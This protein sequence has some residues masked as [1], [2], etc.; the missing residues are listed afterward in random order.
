MLLADHALAILEEAEN[1]AWPVTRHLQASGQVGGKFKAITPKLLACL[2]R[3]S[4][5]LGGSVA[6]EFWKELGECSPGVRE[7]VQKLKVTPLVPSMNII[8]AVFCGQEIDKI[9]FTPVFKMAQEFFTHLI[10]AFNNPGGRKSPVPG[11]V[12]DVIGLSTNEL[13]ELLEAHGDY[14]VRHQASL[15]ELA[16]RRDGV[17]CPFTGRLLRRIPSNRQLPGITSRVAHIIPDGIHTDPEGDILKCIATFA[18]SS[19]RDLVAH[20]LNNIGNVLNL[21]ADYH[22]EY[23][24]LLWGIEA[25]EDD[26]GNVRYIYRDFFTGISQ[27]STND[28]HEIKFGRGLEGE[29]LGKG[30]L[31]ALCNLALGVRRVMKMSGASGLV[32]QIEEDADDTGL[33]EFFLPSEDFCRIVDAKLVLNGGLYDMN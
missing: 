21:T 12:S 23:D 26:T 29:K 11:S 28:G 25:S 16:F 3:E 1:W 30:P 5:K 10:I 13:L 18:G 33:P 6:E 14:G 24:Y 2:I 4:E 7:N 27:M 22:D 31:P 19:T 9:D 8:D 15:R 20:N 17:T 32:S